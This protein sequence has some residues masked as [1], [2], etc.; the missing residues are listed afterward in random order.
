MQS[1][2]TSEPN[3]N[4]FLFYADAAPA[5]YDIWCLGDSFLQDIFN[6]FHTVMYEA[7]RNRQETISPFMSEYYNVMGDYKLMPGGATQVIGRMINT[8]IHVINKRQK[9]P[10]YLIVIPDKDVVNDVDVFEEDSHIIIQELTR[11]LVRQID[12]IVRRKKLELLQIKPGA[13]T[14]YTPK[15]I[16][17]HML[18]QAG[19]YSEESK[20]FG[21]CSL[22]AKFNDALN[23]AVSKSDQYILTINSCNTY[24]HYDH[25]GGLSQKGKLA[26]WHKMD[27][28]IERFEKDKVKLRPTPVQRYN[29]QDHK[30]NRGNNSRNNDR[31]RR[32]PS[33]PPRNGRNFNNY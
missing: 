26:F 11:W 15:I 22:R 29:K 25:H 5:V 8:L 30:K 14:G 17:V 7:E 3:Q 23:N 9:L 27:D 21:V 18:R 2:G 24:D 12:M 32:L 4:I 28:L 1:S 6:T 33:P 31:R 10:K 13:L 20:I 16:Y 19:A